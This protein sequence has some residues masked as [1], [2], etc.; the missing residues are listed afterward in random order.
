MKHA[1]FASLALLAWSA[2]STAEVIAKTHTWSWNVTV[3]RHGDAWK[4]DC[5]LL[6]IAD[7]FKGHHQTSLKLKGVYCALFGPVQVLASETSDRNTAYVFFEAMRGGDG[8]HSSPTVE[9]Y[10]ITKGGLRK[11]GEQSLNEASYKRKGETFVS[12]TGNV[13]YSF[14]DVC[15]GGQSADPELDFA[16]PVRVTIGCGGICVNSTL[17][18]AEKTALIAK[19]ENRKAQVLASA[20][21]DERVKVH[22]KWLEGVFREML[23]K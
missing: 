13:V 15:A 7:G 16:I 12:V 14:C 17:N 23:R 21:T 1:L 22:V 4:E 5:Q 6:L 2:P 20:D 8:D 19:F 11:L 10:S 3:E 18:K 9:I